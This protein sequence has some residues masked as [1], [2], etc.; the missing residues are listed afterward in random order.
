M[1]VLYSLLLTGALFVSRGATALGVQPSQIKNLVTFGDSYTD[2]TGKPAD[3]GTP[4]PIYAADYGNFSLYPYARSGATCSNNLTFRP[5]PSL[6]E[7]Q[8][9]QYF[10][11]RADGAFQVNEDETVYTL[12]IGTNDLGVNSLIVGQGTP[13]V[14]VVNTS[15]CAVNW[16]KTLY[17][18]GAR[19][20][21]FQNMV[22]LEHAIL[23][24][25]QSYLNKYWFDPKN[26]TAWSVSMREMTQTGNALSKL[27]LQVLAPTLPGAHV[28]LF[29]S[30]GLFQDIIDHPANYLN[31]TAPLNT[32]GAID[33][34]VYTE[35]GTVQSCTI[36]TG[37]D[38]D[39]FL[40]YDE[41]HPAEQPNRIVAREIAKAAGGEG[42]DW[43]T[44]LS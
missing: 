24:S 9:P 19:N 28:G 20:F 44:W 25:N 34:C 13:G 41:L 30:N 39:S 32:T 17:D 3:Y 7:S 18:N 42:S 16:V 4:W 38:K 14:T 35:A 26:S 12:W 15:S 1:S 27:L 43:A 22:P 31:G 40:W 29:N 36:A 11:D 6:F 2:V 33:A 37:T 10:S 23:Y 21:L 8:L 5:Y